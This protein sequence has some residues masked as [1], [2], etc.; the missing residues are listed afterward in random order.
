MYRD[1]APYDPECI[2]QEEWLNSRGAIARFDRKA[3]EIRL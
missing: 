3:I 2:L 1:I